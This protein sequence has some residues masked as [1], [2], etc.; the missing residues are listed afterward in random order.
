MIDLDG[1]LRIWD[2]SIIVDAEAAHGLPPG[3]LR[4]AVF[5][6]ISLLHRAITGEI[7]DEE[8][9][10][11]IA[12]GLEASFGPGGRRAVLEWSR[13]AGRVDH[14]V[15]RVLRRERG[16]RTVALFSN[17]TS[18]L[19]ADLD[20]LNLAGEFD[21]VFNSSTLGMAKPAGEAFLAVAES[22]NTDPTQ[23]FFVD[24]SEANVHAA[25]GVG[26]RT[27]HYVDPTALERALTL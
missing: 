14:E 27:H 6:D 2:A 11:Q 17:A 3:R 25:A 7:T 9:R 24:D 16:C 22:L 10:E 5:D 21:I 8:W 23:C 1:V 18:R 19:D 4:E 12:A 13:P 15:L 20:R 26:F